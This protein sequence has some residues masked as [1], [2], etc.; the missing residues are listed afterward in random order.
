MTSLKVQIRLR[1]QNICRLCGVCQKQQ[2]LCNGDALCLLWGRNCCLH[3]RCTDCRLHSFKPCF[4]AQNCGYKFND[5]RRR[6]LSGVDRLSADCRGWMGSECP[7]ISALNNTTARVCNADSMFSVYVFFW[8]I[9]RR[10]NFI[11]RRFGTLC[12]IFIG[13]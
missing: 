11:C 1:A 3:T 7:A 10:L 4:A 5:D 8:V 12:S 6:C 13:K 9:P 2:L